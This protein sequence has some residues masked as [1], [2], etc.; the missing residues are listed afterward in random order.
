MVDKFV[1]DYGF[2]PG[3]RKFVE[4]LESIKELATLTNDD[5]EID[6][7]KFRSELS[8][9]NEIAEQQREQIKQNRG[10]AKLALV[11]IGIAI[12]SFLLGILSLFRWW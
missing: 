3:M 6:F 2:E 5:V 7:S 12:G 8:V 1:M 4:N 9:L 10:T 11:A